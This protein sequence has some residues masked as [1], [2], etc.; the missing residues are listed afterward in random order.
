MTASS[1]PPTLPS[2]PQAG[3]GMQRAPDVGRAQLRAYDT[4]ATM[5]RRTMLAGA[6]LLVTSPARAEP[7]LV[8]IR[9]L[10]AAHGEFSDLA[11]RLNGTRIAVR[12]YMAPPLKPEI[13]F[14]VL[15]KIPMAFCPFC[16]NAAS[17]PEDLMLVKVAGATRI[18]EFNTLITTEGVLELGTATDEATGFVSRVRLVSASYS[19]V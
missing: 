12:G 4:I 11:K 8:K 3:G 14:F 17:W 5:S 6:A 16:D 19:L 9:D 10:W 18:V 7:E 15:T 1:Q 13:D 2:P